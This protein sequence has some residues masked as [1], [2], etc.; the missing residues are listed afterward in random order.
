V[1]KLGKKFATHPVGTGPYE[2]TSWTPKQKIVLNRFAKYA[3][4]N[5]AFVRG[6]AFESINVIPIVN[7]SAAETALRAGDID[8]TEIATGSVDRLKATRA[9]SRSRATADY[10]FLAM[11]VTDELLR[12]EPVA[13]H[14]LGDRRPVIGPPTTARDARQRHHPENMGLGYWKAHRLPARRREAKA[15][16]AKTAEQHHATLATRTTRRTRP[17][18]GDQANLKDIGTRPTEDHRR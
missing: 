1:L 10:Q 17:S 18:S 9:S 5:K 15:F 13:G 14:P 8:F 11:N 16:L 3:G 12:I 4:A 6:P 2:F 7:D